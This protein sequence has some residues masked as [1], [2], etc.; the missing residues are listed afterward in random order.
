MDTQTKHPCGR[1]WPDGAAL[2]IACA[3][4]WTMLAQREE[5]DGRP[6]SA[7]ISARVCGRLAEWAQRAERCRRAESQLQGAENGAAYAWAKAEAQ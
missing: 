4:C 7:S 3:R 2:A 1:T 6:A 5:E